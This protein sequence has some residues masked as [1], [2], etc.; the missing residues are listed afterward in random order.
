MLLPN[1]LNLQ[2]PRPLSFSP[3]TPFKFPFL[4]PV[5]SPA[6]F[7]C[8]STSPSSSNSLSAH[9]SY[10]FDQDHVIGDC[11]VFEDGIFEDPYLETEANRKGIAPNKPTSNK[12]SESEPENLVPDQWREVQAE[13][14][15]SKKQRRKIAQEIEFG[16]KVEK[17][18]QGYMPLRDVPLNEYRTFR[19]AKL[20]ELSPL[21]LDNP[22]SFPIKV[23]DA[24]KKAY[25]SERVAPRDP[26]WEVYG[27]GLDDVREFFN[28]GNYEPGQMN[29]EGIHFSCA[30]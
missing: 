4:Q 11:I 26:R 15:I 27:R 18:K 3:A 8:H 1:V 16:R 22:T 21:V 5:K 30:L 14:N 24:E 6:Q 23:D 7:H 9:H 17:R 25:P 12:F 13:L 19:E 28:S 2:I 29:S 10:D 20:K